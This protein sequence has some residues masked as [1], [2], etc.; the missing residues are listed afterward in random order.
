VVMTSV[1][2]Y[3]DSMAEFSQMKT[4]ELWY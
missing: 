2:T 1:R 4:L 3:R